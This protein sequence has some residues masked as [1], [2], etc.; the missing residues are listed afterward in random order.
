M[1]A[2]LDALRAQLPAMDAGIL[3]DANN[4]EVKRSALTPE[5]AAV[6]HDYRL[7]Q[8]DLSIGK[9]YIADAMF[10]DAN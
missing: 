8:Y 6:L 10:A 1:Y 3:I 7:V 2:L 4:N 9:R 5:Q